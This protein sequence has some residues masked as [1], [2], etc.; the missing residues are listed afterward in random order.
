MA[1]PGWIVRGGVA[2]MLA[3]A[4]ALPVFAQSA[5]DFRLQP[6][7]PS[8][9]PRPQGPVDPDNPTSTPT[10]TRTATPPTPAPAAST[11][12]AAPAPSSTTAPPSPRPST[13]Q[14]LPR[15]AATPAGPAST[16]RITAPA[17]GAAP[18]SVTPPGAD[19]PPASLPAPATP[20][21]APGSE[22]LAQAQGGL[23]WWWLVP[24]TILVVALALLFIGHRRRRAAAE[25]VG[26][27]PGFQSAPAVSPPPQLNR[28]PQQPAPPPPAPA[29]QPVEALPEPAFAGNPAEPIGLALVATR[30]SATLINTTLSYR[31][32]VEN[33]GDAPLG[34]VRVAGDMIAAHGALPVEQQ[35]ATDG[36][37]LEPRHEIT[38]LDPGERIELRGELR[39]PLARINPIRSGAVA[40]FVPLA[41]FRAEA[42]GATTLATFVVGEAPQ[43]ATSAALMPFRLDLGPRIYSQV[44][45]RRIDPLAA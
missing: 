9:A 36:Q 1:I 18:P 13:A 23:A 39:L 40:L 5:G 3:L 10:P 7:T 35:L 25:A 29:P 12:P 33:R 41:R 14:P 30:L 37:P 11:A 17:I 38:S 34:P 22:P 45:Q 16:Q 20:S 42:D 4:P 26:F 43:T 19:L 24:P 8:A 28:R 15:T 27:E 31:L 2:A 21:F 44:S 32:V 6:G